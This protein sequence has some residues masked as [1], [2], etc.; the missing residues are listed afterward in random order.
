MFMP[1]SLVRLLSY[2]SRKRLRRSFTSSILNMANKTPSLDKPLTSFDT[3]PSVGE[4][5]YIT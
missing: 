5:N 4:E 2:I 1:M 3:A